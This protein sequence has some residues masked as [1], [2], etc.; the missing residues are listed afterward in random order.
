MVS[1]S[2]QLLVHNIRAMQSLPIQATRDGQ[3]QDFKRETNE[4]TSDVTHTCTCTHTA[5]NSRHEQTQQ[6][7]T[8][9]KHRWRLQSAVKSYSI[10][11]RAGEA[12][13]P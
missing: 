13:Q 11:M 1:S 12:T 5:C 2:A 8:G 6:P 4:S 3:R 9:T 10:N 7:S